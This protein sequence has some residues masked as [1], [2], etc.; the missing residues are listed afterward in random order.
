[1]HHILSKR[2]CYLTLTG[3]LH[4][5]FG[6][7]PAGPA[8]TGKTETTKVY[9]LFKIYL[10]YLFIDFVRIYYY[11]DIIGYYLILYIFI[12]YTN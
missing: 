11:F 3:A 4:L 12:S 10:T 7:A 6:G 9:Y 1:M 5:N 2:R 8:G